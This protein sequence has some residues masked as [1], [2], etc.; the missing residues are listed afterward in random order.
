MFQ[1]SNCEKPLKSWKIIF[2]IFANSQIHSFTLKHQKHTENRH[3][4]CNL[5]LAT[6]SCVFEREK[7]AA[8]NRRHIKFSAQ[9]N[10]NL[11]N[12]LEKFGIGLNYR[13]INFHTNWVFRFSVRFY[14][15]KRE[16]ESKNVVL[17]LVILFTNI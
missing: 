1:D 9:F 8:K 11:W 4:V 10:A 13:R 7:K 15:W 3:I 16:N 14:C 17:K 12:H 6:F 5:L 2:L